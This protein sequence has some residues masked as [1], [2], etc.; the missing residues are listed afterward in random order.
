MLDSNAMQHILTEELAQGQQKSREEM[1]EK[2]NSEGRITPLRKVPPNTF[3][4]A[5]LRAARRQPNR[6]QANLGYGLRGHRFDKATNTDN[7]ARKTDGNRY[8]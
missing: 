6:R 8:K 7:R 4:K 5:G 2:V 3:N 1:L